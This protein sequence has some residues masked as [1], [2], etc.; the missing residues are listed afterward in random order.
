M[1]PEQSSNLKEFVIS[2]ALAV[3][4]FVV[5]LVLGYFQDNTLYIGVTLFVCVIAIVVAYF[6]GYHKRDKKK[7]TDAE[8]TVQK[9]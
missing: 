4:A 7:K 8:P 9:I 6:I 2:A 5:L 1:E 3:I